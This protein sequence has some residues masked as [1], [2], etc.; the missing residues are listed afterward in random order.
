MG[1]DKKA[2]KVEALETVASGLKKF[3]V[4]FECKQIVRSTVEIE[5]STRTDAEKR[6]KANADDLE[7]LGFISIITILPFFGFMA[8]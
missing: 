2:E 6:F 1:T 7:T 8:N 5:A 4:E 3:L